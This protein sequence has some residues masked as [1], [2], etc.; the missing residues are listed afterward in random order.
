MRHWWIVTFA[1]VA[2]WP[3]LGYTENL[4]K[5]VT[6]SVTRSTLDQP[7]TKPFHLKATVAPSFERDKDS[8]RTGVLEIWWVSPTQWK[9]EV[10][11]PEFHQVEVVNG[12]RGWQKNDGD[13]FPE[14]LRETAVALI[15]PVPLLQVLE[16]VKAAE[17]RRI[18]LMTNLS[19]TTTTGTA[20][21]RNISRSSIAW[22][23][24][25]GL[26]LYASGFGWGGEFKD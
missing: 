7:G 21:V 6:Q 20:E 24:S 5:E 4:A 22:Q 12:D 17:V 16:Q 2:V 3:A 19:W 14:W 8:G 1:A 9:R 13:Y 23:T 10:R 25:T 15:R 11:S 26:L 18:G